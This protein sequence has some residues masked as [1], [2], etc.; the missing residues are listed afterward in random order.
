MMCRSSLIKFL[1]KIFE[2]NKAQRLQER[3]WV[4]GK[5]PDMK[6]M[7]ESLKQKKES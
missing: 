3:L 4:L 7:R 6:K 1:N 2:R 5:N